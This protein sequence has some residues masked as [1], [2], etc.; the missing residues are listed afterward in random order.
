MRDPRL[1]PLSRWELR[2]FWGVTQREVVISCRRF[3]TTY[4]SHP[5]GSIIQNILG[6]LVPEDGTD[7][8]Y[9]NVGKK[10]K[11]I[12]C[13]TPQKSAFLK[14]MLWYRQLSRRPPSVHLLWFVR[15]LCWIRWHGLDFVS[16]YFGF[17]LSVSF[18][19]RP[20]YCFIHLPP[21]ILN[22]AANNDAKQNAHT[23]LC[24]LQ[25]RFPW[26]IYCLKIIKH[27]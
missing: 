27:S 1:P 7:T 10:L 23:H 6:F 16:G 15:D 3:G 25:D 14:A 18:R 11:T 4:R 8:L 22:S 21:S 9:R 26:K 12:R 20:S 24:F 19:R 13:L 2:F 5:Q 17:P